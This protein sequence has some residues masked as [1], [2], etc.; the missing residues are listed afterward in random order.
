MKRQ[1]FFW[2]TL[3]AIFFLTG[4]GFFDALF[5]DTQY[6]NYKEVESIQTRTS[7]DP[8]KA[9]LFKQEIE[10]SVSPIDADSF[11]LVALNSVKNDGDLMKSRTNLESFRQTIGT[12][13]RNQDQEMYLKISE[14]LSNLVSK[15]QLSSDEMNA[16]LDRIL[17]LEKYSSNLST[18]SVIDFFYKDKSSPKSNFYNP[19]LMGGNPLS[20][21]R[22]EFTNKSSV[23]KKIKS[24]SFQLVTDGGELLTP[25]STSMLKESQV[26]FGPEKVKNAARFNMPDELALIPGQKIVKY[27]AFPAISTTTKFVDFSIID[28]SKVVSERFS[29]SYESSIIKKRYNEKFITAVN[30]VTT[31]RE[32]LVYLLNFQNKIFILPE[33]VFFIADEEIR[34]EIR[35]VVVDYDVNGQLYFGTLTGRVNELLDSK[36]EIRVKL[37]KY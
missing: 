2:F 25:F 30:Y 1:H 5:G 23:L 9:S 21:F 18:Q 6:L 4:C 17:A 24:S 20:V 7:F 31:R 37:S 22:I 27:L 33:D 13:Q 19:Y 3:P 14:K 16:I 32:E 12:G 36:N 10:I 8:L 28:S 11:D 15:N 35:V 34:S 26:D 29:M